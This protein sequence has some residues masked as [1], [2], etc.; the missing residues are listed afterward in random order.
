M[1]F[2]LIEL[3]VVIAI[4]AIL[5]A[6]LLPALQNARELVR[7]THCTNNMKQLGTAMNLYAADYDGNICC[8][9]NNFL[10]DLAPYVGREEMKTGP[11]GSPGVMQC[12]TALMKMPIVPSNVYHATAAY[13]VSLL[14]QNGTYMGVRLNKIAIPSKCMF[15]ADTSNWNTTW[16]NWMNGVGVPNGP[17][18][19]CVHGGGLNPSTA[20]MGSGLYF[21]D[22]KAVYV[23]ADNHAAATFP[24]DY[25]VTRPPAGQRLEFNRFWL[26][27]DTP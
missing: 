18:S 22:G 15:L 10:L 13:N 5:A 2:T 19:R 6:L 8:G 23:Y 26:A 24:E 20:G 4:I 21:K 11:K 25:H 17:I 12:P 7:L 1:R 9:A 16:S 3:L 14:A 27:S